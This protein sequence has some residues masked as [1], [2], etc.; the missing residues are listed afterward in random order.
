MN[1]HAIGYIAIGSYA[2]IKC[3]PYHQSKSNYAPA[4]LYAFTHEVV[5]YIVE[6]FRYIKPFLLVIPWTT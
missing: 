6:D 1:Q 5:N 2:V 3:V 4:W